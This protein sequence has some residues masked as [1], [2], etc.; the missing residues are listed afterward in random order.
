LR[1]FLPLPRL[2]GLMGELSQRIVAVSAAVRDELAPHIAG[3]KLAVIHTGLPDPGPAPV[4]DKTAV[5][6]VA[7]DTPVVA[8]VGLL[9]HRKGVVDLIEAAR[10]VV[11]AMPQARFVLAGRDGG[12]AAEVRRLID[13]YALGSAVRWLG[14]RSDVPAILAASDLLVL[15]SLAD[16]LPVAVL[17][18]MS[19][20]LPAAATRSGGCE[21]MVA[22][23]ETGLL[24]PPGDRPA[25]A[26]AIL[27]LLGDPATRAAMGARGRARFLAE[28]TQAG[29]VE[30]FARLIEETIAARPAAALPPRDISPVLDELR[31]AACRRAEQ[32]RRSASLAQRFN[33]RLLTLLYRWRVVR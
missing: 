12:A 1:P 30:R 26:A 21:E 18:A 4:I 28:F 5:L 13:R 31:A 29:Y 16:P 8:F 23:G 17:E 10:L 14:P 32:R 2:Y 6:G 22:D 9:S 27:R 20:G 15:P 33:E 19:F 7:H 25:L 3:D 11:A 24:V